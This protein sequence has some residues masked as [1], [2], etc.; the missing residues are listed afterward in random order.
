MAKWDSNATPSTILEG[1]VH[2][3]QVSIIAAGCQWCSRDTGW[4][5]Q[6][7]RC[8]QPCRF[9]VSQLTA[10]GRNPSSTMYLT[11]QMVGM[12]PPPQVLQQ[13]QPALLRQWSSQHYAPG[14]VCGPDP[15]RREGKA[16]GEVSRSSLEDSDRVS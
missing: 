7:V 2:Q 15:Q 13:Q 16:R 8:Q 14:K 11:E 5:P 3:T 10:P 6:R 4:W 12:N 9:G 1:D